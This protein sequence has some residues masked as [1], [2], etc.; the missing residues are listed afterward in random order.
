[1]RKYDKYI[2]KLVLFCAFVFSPIIICA[3]AIDLY[4]GLRTP[5]SD[6]TIV[7]FSEDRNQSTRHRTITNDDESTCW[8]SPFEDDDN[9][10]KYCLVSFV[11]HLGT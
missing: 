4:T 9:D 10:G 8:E 7:L 3:Y 1:M 11:V 2:I 6:K 5:R